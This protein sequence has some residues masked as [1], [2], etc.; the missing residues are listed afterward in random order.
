VDE[1]PD[2]SDFDETVYED[3]V[4][5]ARF[6]SEQYAQMVL[7]ALRSKDIPSVIFSGAGHFGIT[8]QMGLSSF[9]P[10]DGAYSLLVP[11]EYI[12]EADFEGSS[13]LGEEW[14]NSRVSD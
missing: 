2:D 10:I 1:L 5:I 8:G 12:D 14:E 3:W 6:R 13:L 11:K 9:R 4:R 7:D